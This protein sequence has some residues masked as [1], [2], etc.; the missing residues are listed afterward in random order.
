[1]VQA[2]EK[3]QKITEKGASDNAYISIH[4]PEILRL[5]QAKQDQMNLDP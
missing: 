1:M 5:K 3:L 2:L 4:K